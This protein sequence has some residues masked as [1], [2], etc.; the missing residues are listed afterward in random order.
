M[1]YSE[2]GMTVTIPSDL[3]VQFAE[4]MIDVEAVREN[5]EMFKAEYGE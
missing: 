4:Y 5:Y 3:W 1:E 2:D